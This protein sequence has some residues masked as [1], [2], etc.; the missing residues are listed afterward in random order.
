M[1]RSYSG[2][3]APV[4]APCCARCRR[5]TARSPGSVT[6]GIVLAGTRER[7]PTS[8]SSP[9]ASV[10]L[11]AADLT[12]A[13]VATGTEPQSSPGAT[14]RASAKASAR[15]LGCLRDALLA[16]GVRQVAAR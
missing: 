6:L 1:T 14:I 3:D 12:P 15:D 10:F 5:G 2:H 4:G 16:P 11:S 13:G 7:L 8:R 9:A